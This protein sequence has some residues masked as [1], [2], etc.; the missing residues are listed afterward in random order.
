MVLDL[1]RTQCVETNKLS[2]LLVGHR[3]RER[4][5]SRAGAVGDLGGTLLFYFVDTNDRVDR[6]EAPLHAREFSEQFVLT[7]ID[8]H[9]RFFP[10]NVV[11]DFDE[12][13]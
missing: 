4:R 10:E 2:A 13:I 12:A 7:R 3:E 8:H 1:S 6:D 11:F 5:Y 9:L